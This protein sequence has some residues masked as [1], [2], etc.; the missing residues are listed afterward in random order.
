MPELYAISLGELANAASPPSPLVREASYLLHR[1]PPLHRN[2][3]KRVVKTP[4]LH[5]LD[6][7]LACWLL[8]IRSADE[9]RRHPL[10][11]PLMESWVVAEVRKAFV[12]S[13]QRA[14]L[15][16]WRDHGGREV[17]LV[18][19]PPRCTPGQQG[20]GPQGAIAEGPRVA[21]AL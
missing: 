12:N 6:T 13:G 10:R 20:A 16:H 4:K 19:D 14:R 1:L 8:G 21:A 18:V 7:G 3:K 15:H 5:L 9:L 2:L 11:G 17:D